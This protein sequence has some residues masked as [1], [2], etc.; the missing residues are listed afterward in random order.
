MSDH[1]QEYAQ[2]MLPAVDRQLRYVVEQTDLSDLSRFKRYAVLPH[3]LG[4]G[5]CPQQPGEKDPSIDVISS[6]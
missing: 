4:R 3:G 6:R 2:L 1:I 5:A